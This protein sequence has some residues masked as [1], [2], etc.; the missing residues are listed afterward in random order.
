MNGRYEHEIPQAR[1]E[2]TSS[3]ADH[4]LHEHELENIASTHGG[5]APECD[6]MF[7]ALVVDAIP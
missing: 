5:V 2:H 6:V 3:S 4:D 1:F 7:H